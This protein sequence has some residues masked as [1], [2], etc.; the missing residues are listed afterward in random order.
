[1]P[2][3]YCPSCGVGIKY[4][5]QK[6]AECNSCNYVFASVSISSLP[7]K[8]SK[9]P[10]DE[11]E[12]EDEGEWD[13]DYKVGKTFEK[14]EESHLSNSARR[15][16]KKIKPSLDMNSMSFEKIGEV[17]GTDPNAKREKRKAVSKD[18]L[19]SKIFSPKENNIEDA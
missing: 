15:K 9:R 12:D 18:E 8:K 13:K 1:M 7:S 17:V 14:F 6:P 16:F 5:Y 3:L 4:L 11:E 19:R 10:I 2:N